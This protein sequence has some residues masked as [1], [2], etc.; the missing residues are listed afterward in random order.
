MEEITTY[1]VDA[2]CMNCDWSGQVDVPKGLE[3][4]LYFKFSH[5]CPRCRTANLSKTVAKVIRDAGW[6]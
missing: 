4:S 1:R 6:F 3:I 5:M 2:R